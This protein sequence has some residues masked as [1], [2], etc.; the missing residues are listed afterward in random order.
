MTEIMTGEAMSEIRRWLQLYRTIDRA[1]HQ[2]SPM[3]APAMDNFVGGASLIAKAIITSQPNTE[4]DVADLLRFAIDL[5]TDSDGWNSQA[6]QASESALAHAA[7]LACM[8]S[9]TN[10]LVKT[11]RLLASLDVDECGST[12]VRTFVKHYCPALEAAA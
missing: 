2:F 4:A 12:G 11:V 1:L 8:S 6:N 3:P 5:M 9:A 7:K 10:E